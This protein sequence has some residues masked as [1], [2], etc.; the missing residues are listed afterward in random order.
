[1]PNADVI[2]EHTFHTPITDHAFLEPECSIAVPLPDGRM[3]I[4]VGSQIPYQ[5]RTQ[6]ARALGWPEERMRI[7]GQLMGGGFGGKEDIAGQ[8]HA[9]MLANVTGR[10]GEAA[11]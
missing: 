1:M 8:I 2:L 5:D 3:E 4:Y 6:V 7:V 9:A 10:P 11:V